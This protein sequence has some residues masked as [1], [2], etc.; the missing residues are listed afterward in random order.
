[1]SLFSD[2][3]KSNLSAFFGADNLTKQ[4]KLFDDYYPMADDMSFISI[5]SAAKKGI[6]AELIPF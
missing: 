5:T 2:F 4:K 6:V 3:K 1:V